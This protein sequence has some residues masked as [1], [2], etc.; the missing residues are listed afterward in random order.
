MGYSFIFRGMSKAA[1]P[2]VPSLGREGIYR[3]HG[4]AA[5]RR[6]LDEFRYRFAA[7]IDG[8]PYD[9]WELPAFAQHVGVPTRLL[10][11]STSPLIALFFALCADN[12]AN[13]AIYCFSLSKHRNEVAKEERLTSSPFEVKTVR[14]FSPPLSFPRLRNQRRRLHCSTRSRRGFAA[15]HRQENHHRQEAGPHV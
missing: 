10:D 9:E 5:E 13:R 14:R 6:L 12:D 2:L 4:K 11:W 7:Q 3:R 15:R 8:R 1:Y